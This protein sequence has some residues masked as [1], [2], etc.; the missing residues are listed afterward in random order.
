MNSILEIT[1]SLKKRGASYFDEN[2]L[3]LF[4]SEIKEKFDSCIY[5]YQSLI[6]ENESVKLNFSFLTNKAIFDIEL[7]K[8]S[9]ETYMFF[10]K[11][12]STINEE[13][14]QTS[15]TLKI[16]NGGSVALFYKAYNN[17]DRIILSEYSKRIINEIN[18]L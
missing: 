10:L 3:E 18:K 11:D 12:I 2:Y 8:N 16:F 1:N 5:S 14:T 13:I 9:V 7:K 4:V 15:K 6:Q 17:S